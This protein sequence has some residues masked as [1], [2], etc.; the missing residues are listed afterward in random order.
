MPSMRLLRRF[1]FLLILLTLG[2][3]IFQNQALLGQ[4]TEFVFLQWR[5]S[6]ILGFWILFSF[7]AGWLLFLLIDLRKSL[8]LRM[9]MRRKDQLIARLEKQVML[10]APSANKPDSVR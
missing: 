2:I 3:F 9:E 5:L 1:S 10:T 7:I 4:P 8:Q 6:I